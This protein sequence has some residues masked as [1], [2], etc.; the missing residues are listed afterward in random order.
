MK[1]TDLEPILDEALRLPPERRSDYLVERLGT[2]RAHLVAELLQAEADSD[3]QETD[4]HPRPERR[5]RSGLTERVIARFHGEIVDSAA[6]PAADPGQRDSGERAGQ[7]PQS[8]SDVAPE[9]AG[10]YVLGRPLGSGG[11]GAV[12]EGRRDDGVVDRTV[13]VKIVRADRGPQWEDRLRREREVLAKLSHPG[14]TPLFDAGV[15]EDGRPYL[16]MEQVD[17]HPI[18]QYCDEGQL[19]VRARCELFLQVLDALEHAHG[20]LVI[21]RDLK[22]SNV[23]V[24]RD[25]R[26]RLLDFGIAKLLEDADQPG[27]T[28][29]RMRLFTPQY[30]APEQVRGEEPSTATDVYGAGLLLYELLASRRAFGDESSAQEIVRPSLA[31]ASHELE[32]LESAARSRSTTPARWAASLR[33]DLDAVLLMALRAD[34][35]ERYRSIGALRTDLANHLEGLPVTAR[36][37]GWRYS[38]SRFWR[39]HRAATAAGI[40]AVLALVVGSAVASWQAVQAARERDRAL[41]AEQS[42]ESMNRFL[43]DLLLAP[44]TTELGPDARLLDIMDSARELASESVADNAPTRGRILFLIGR[45]KASLGQPREAAAILEEAESVLAGEDAPEARLTSLRARIRRAEILLEQPDLE[46]AGSLLEGVHR[47]LEAFP[48]DAQLWA[49]WARLEGRRRQR[50]SGPAAAEE[51]FREALARLEANGSSEQRTTIHSDLAVVLEGQGKLDEAEKHYREALGWSLD[52]KGERFETTLVV[53][54]NLG[55][56]LAQSGKLQEAEEMFRTAEEVSREWLG[57]EHPLHVEAFN[58]VLGVLTDRG[59]IEAA[60]AGSEESLRLSEAAWGRRHPRFFVPQMNIGNRYLLVGRIA[61]AEELLREASAGLTETVGANAPPTL[62]CQMILSELLLGT[63]RP[64]EAAALAES[65]I[66][67]ATETFGPDGP[68]TLGLQ[69]KL[70]RALSRLGETER[71]L[72]AMRASWSGLHAVFGE[73]SGETL[74]AQ[75]SLAAYL[76]DQGETVEGRELLCSAL[77]IAREALGAGHGT[78]KTLERLAA[79]QGGCTAGV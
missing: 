66:E 9:R 39:R 18:D 8:T 47:E 50:V 7:G 37:G 4:E 10:P 29:A 27:L 45:V 70:G 56:L 79:E 76:I 65:A 53:R 63:D 54:L 52:S 2:E 11:M 30:A 25:G 46:S 40:L 57:V 64:A 24:D 61:E 42:A 43:T 68:M 22:P 69:S 19:T 5:N 78:R 33:G 14:I 12:F 44:D 62:Y 67:R 58:N 71:A 21:H 23:L 15:L 35:T 49:S 17:G 60:L 74:S 41:A 6:L 1:W 48:R 26:V 3:D 59:E 16:V 73:R 32:E 36:R 75:L 31:V 34:P 77:G 55:G 38:A 28:G 20:R 51:I 13:A 72:A